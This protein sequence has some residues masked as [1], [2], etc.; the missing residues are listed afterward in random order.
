MKK[1]IKLIGLDLDGTVFNNNKIISTRTKKA[2]ENAIQKGVVVLPSTGRPF[3]GV[4]HDFMNINGVKYVLTSNGAVIRDLHSEEIIY[5]DLMD[6][7]LSLRIVNAVSDYN[8]LLE[9]YIEGRGYSDNNALK[10]A[11][12]YIKDDALADYIIK[13]RIGIDDLSDFVQSENKAIEK[14]HLLFSDLSE[15]ERVMEV[16]MKF[17]DE[18]V[19]TSAMPNNI[20]INKK[21]VNKG[22]GLL[23]LGKLLGIKREQIMACGDGGNDIEMIKAVGFGVAMG[24][25]IEE[26]KEVADYVTLTNEDDGVAYAIEQFVL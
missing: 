21:T 18:I 9:V 25:A 6:V 13:S 4:P 12:S 20:E 2:I 1:D 10:S 7:D 16:L 17:D 14:I 3:S 26:V 23:A 15:K 11:I 8:S 19:I 22:N 5:Q 24:N